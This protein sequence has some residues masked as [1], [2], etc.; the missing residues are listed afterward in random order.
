MDMVISFIGTG[1]GAPSPD[2]G[3]PAIFLRRGGEAF[4]FDCGEGTQIGLKRMR[5]GFSGLENIFVTH[6][7]GDH[8]LGVPGL[9]M[10][11]SL[12]A[13]PEKVVVHGPQG[14]RRLV[15]ETFKRTWFEP[16]FNVEFDELSPTSQPTQV[17]A[18]EGYKIVS[19]AADHGMPSLAY[20][21]IEDYRPGV[22]DVEACGRLG[23]PKGPLWG[24]LQRGE[25][26]YVN[27]RR[28]L[29]EQVM[30]PKRK[31]RTVVYSGDTRPCERVLDLAKGADVFM[32]EATMPDDCL[33]EAIEGGHST[34]TQALR[35]LERSGCKQGV[36][37]NFGQKVRIRD[38][39]QILNGF[40]FALAARDGLRIP[41]RLS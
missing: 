7:H 11:L 2:R 26:V 25:A 22:F 33:E 32:H 10:S 21:L 15:E 37:T 19:V 8:V 31:G 4:L 35:L 24:K 1:A 5:L 27:G 13:S 36:L 40:P 17:L 16:K 18:G 23:V 38:L 12:N 30:G 20:G 3:A 6:M 28:I 34:V 29:P 39:E 41:V 9:I 14:I